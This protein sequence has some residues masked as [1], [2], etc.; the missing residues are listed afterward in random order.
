MVAIM[1]DSG[2]EEELLPDWEE[3]VTVDECLL[4]WIDSI[5]QEIR[6]NNGKL[7]YSNQILNTDHAYG[8]GT[9]D[10]SLMA[11]PICCL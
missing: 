5:T 11:C 3:R 10:G 2:S 1:S 9:T 8:S 7:G 6:K 4:S